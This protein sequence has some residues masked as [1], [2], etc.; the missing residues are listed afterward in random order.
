MCYY[1]PHQVRSDAS[2]GGDL[3]S[4]KLYRV[5][6]QI[7]TSPVR[8]IDADGENRGVVPLEEAVEAAISTG[9]DL[10]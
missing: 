9:N 7:R 2:L 3:I 1:N 4:E 6:R 10:V 8:L 5:N